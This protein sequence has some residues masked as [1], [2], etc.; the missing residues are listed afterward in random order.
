NSDRLTRILNRYSMPERDSF[1]QQYLRYYT[2]YDDDKIAYPTRRLIDWAWTPG[3]SNKLDFETTRLTAQSLTWILSSTKVKVRDETTKALVNLLEQQPE[4]LIW[5][6]KKFKN[7]NDLYIS[8]RLYAVA[9]GCILRNANDSFTNKVALTVYNLVFK[10][11]NPPKHILLRDY[12]RNTIEFAFYKNPKLKINLTFIRPPY[13]SELPERLPT[14]EEVLKYN[15][16]YN[17]PEAKRHY[18]LMNNRI[19]HSVTGFGDFSKH[20]DS[21]LDDFAPTSFTFEKHYK[22]FYKSLKT[23]QKKLLKDLTLLLE[24]KGNYN[25]S[26]HIKN[27]LGIEFLNKRLAE[28]DTLFIEYIEL[29]NKAFQNEEKSFI[30]NKVIPFLE[31]KYEYKKWKFSKSEM[32]S[33]KYWII[34]RTF[35]LGY[36]Y[37][38]HGEFDDQISRHSY[39]REKKIERIGKKYQRIS[40]HEI[41]AILSDNYMLN[42]FSW[43]DDKKYEFYKGAWQL[44]IRDIDPA[45]VEKN[46]EEEEEE[47]KNDLGILNEKKEWWEDSDYKYWNQITSEWITN[48]EDLPNP[49]DILEKRDPDNDDWLCLKKFSTWDE[50][51]PMG[52]G[53]Y[54]FQRKEMFYKIQG[55]LVDKKN[56]VKIIKWLSQQNFWGNWMPE[57]RDHNHLINREKFWSPAY[58]DS[59]NE[60]KWE[61]IRDTNLKV[62]IATTNAVSNIDGDK[63]GAQFSY[64]MPCKTIFEGMNLKYAPVDGEFKSLNDQIIVTNKKHSGVLIRKKDL[65]EFLNEKK[66]DIIWTIM[67]E[68]M[69]YS[70]K[71]DTNYRKELSGVYYLENN[72]I[73]GITKAFDSE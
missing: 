57:S 33:F 52:K 66:L 45:F 4:V 55:Y 42:K 40:L 43:H 26:H 61:T 65:M 30:T 68:K 10:K 24:I 46:I 18:K 62:I 72:Q 9:Y 69:C 19:Y 67:G 36:S 34:G 29:I 73:K 38:L 25:K 6:L 23:N 70:S 15:F 22:L 8:E 44:Y 13:K 59:D 21:C 16:P 64:E 63:S 3:I 58:F 31:T 20:I 11:Q 41:L 27:N 1:W 14:D 49:K 39:G 2:E 60:K 5:I 12:A 51:K 48:L 28:L 7:I 53:K 56:K 71:S 32:N 37:E 47:E 17:N 35:E 54:D 50:P